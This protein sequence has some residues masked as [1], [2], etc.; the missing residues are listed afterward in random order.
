[1]AYEPTNNFHSRLQVETNMG[2]KLG[3]VDHRSKD[4]YQAEYTRNS[5]KEKEE[6]ENM[7]MNPVRPPQ[8]KA[9]KPRM[10]K[11]KPADDTKLQQANKKDLDQRNIK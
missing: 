3:V 8:K 1:M 10:V 5:Q 6:R 11:P 9:S 7:N 4:F 2:P